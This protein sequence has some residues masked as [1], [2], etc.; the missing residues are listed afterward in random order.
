MTFSS[1]VFLDFDSVPHPA[2]GVPAYQPLSRLPL[3]ES[4]PR[5]PGMEQID[6]VISSTW[7]AA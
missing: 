4:L 6:V 1:I 5:E 2:G 7:R 3:L